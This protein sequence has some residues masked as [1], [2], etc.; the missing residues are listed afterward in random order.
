LNPNWTR[1]GVCADG[2]APKAGEPK[3]I[4][5]KSR[6]V[7][8]IGAAMLLRQDMFNGMDQFAIFLVQQ[9]IFAMLGSPPPD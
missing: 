2:I 9:A 5:G 3:N 1:R 4:F 6:F 8:I 7:W